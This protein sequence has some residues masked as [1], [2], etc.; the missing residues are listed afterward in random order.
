MSEHGKNFRIACTVK[1]FNSEK[2]FG[3]LESDEI[4]SDIFLHES[5][6]Q[7]FGQNLISQDEC[8]EVIASETGGKFRAVEIVNIEHQGFMN[9]PKLSQ[10][11]SIPDSDILKLKYAACRVKWFDEK[12]GIGF[13][14]EFGVKGDIFIHTSVLKCSGFTS[15][16]SGEAVLLKI[17]SSDRGLIAVDAAPWSK[18]YTS[19]TKPH[20]YEIDLQD[21]SVK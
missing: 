13:A 6:L 11:Q 7:K 20:C 4:D 2:G 17:I 1:W 5:V 16:F 19:H 14:N 21:V 15:L 12:K 9:L 8:I 18:S 3:F 10:L